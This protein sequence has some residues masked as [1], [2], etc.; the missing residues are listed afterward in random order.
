MTRARGAKPDKVYSLETSPSDGRHRL[1]D[2]EK[3]VEV[4]EPHERAR[5]ERALAQRQKKKTRRAAP[6][7]SP[8]AIEAEHA[9]ALAA[10]IPVVAR[11]APGALFGVIDAPPSPYAPPSAPH[12]RPR[13]FGRAEDFSTPH[14][15]EFGEVGTENHGY[16]VWN[17][18]AGGGRGSYVGKT[19]YEPFRNIAEA[20]EYLAEVRLRMLEAGKALSVKDRRRAEAER[21]GTL[22][23]PPRPSAGASSKHHGGSPLVQEAPAASKQRTLFNPPRT[24]ANPPPLYAN[25]AT[26]YGTPPENQTP[27]TFDLADQ[28]R[29]W[30]PDHRVKLHGMDEDTMRVVDQQG[31]EHFFTRYEFAHSFNAAGTVRDGRA[32]YL[33]T[34]GTANP[35]Y[36]ERAHP[37]ALTITPFPGVVASAPVFTHA[38]RSQ[39]FQ[40]DWIL[41]VPGAAPR[42]VM[43][44]QDRQGRHHWFPRELWIAG[45]KVG[46]WV[47]TDDGAWYATADA[48]DPARWTR[49]PRRP[50]QTAAMAGLRQKFS[51]SA[52][53]TG[54]V[55]FY[56]A[57]D[58]A[59]ALRQYADAE[60]QGGTHVPPGFHVAHYRAT[61]TSWWE[62][63][64]IEAEK[65]RVRA[66]EEAEKARSRA[67]HANPPRSLAYHLPPP[68]GFDASEHRTSGPRYAMREVEDTERPF[69]VVDRYE[70]E[71]IDQFAVRRRAQDEVDRRNKPRRAL[72]Y[73]SLPNG[74][75]RPARR[76][77]RPA[78]RARGR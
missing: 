62:E 65:A 23:A 26:K 16:K 40:L 27:V 29:P 36:W 33:V 75:R 51:I 48:V 72:P 1:F 3:Y 2:G 50:K 47:S 28:M 55:A 74:P 64:A 38:A 30:V 5:A 4:F 35:R 59:D 15:K 67:T 11:P 52:P 42:A 76:R 21:G 44:I 77:K 7:P 73:A 22:F 45:A 71:I 61:P 41:H 54:A 69:A 43:T 53:G 12:E 18:L 60:T 9:L 49:L 57:V 39:P 10:P 58:D 68:Q 31:R 63:R 8:A 70:N 46:R 6:A 66:F 25:A 56:D 19:L 78:L 34:G 20:S 24:Y 17:P 13:S 14:I 32:L 37:K